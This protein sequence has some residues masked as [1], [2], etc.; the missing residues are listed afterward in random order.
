M[1]KIR[2]STR[3]SYLIHIVVVGYW[4]EVVYWLQ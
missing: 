3:S 2:V 1:G 4:D